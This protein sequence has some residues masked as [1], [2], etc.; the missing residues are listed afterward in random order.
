MDLF[1]KK[2]CFFFLQKIILF[3]KFVKNRD[4]GE[5]NLKSEIFENQKIK[6]VFF[7]FFNKYFIFKI[8][9]KFK[10]SFVFS[11]QNPTFLLTKKITNIAKK[12]KRFF[13]SNIENK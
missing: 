7:F 5:Q 2:K 3:L 6:I 12:Q 1:N 13:F 4:N 10:N 9:H 8:E 11:F